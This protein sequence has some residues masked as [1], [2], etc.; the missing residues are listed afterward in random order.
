MKLQLFNLTQ[1]IDGLKELIAIN[2]RDE[3]MVLLEA[4]MLELQGEDEVI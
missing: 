4:R 1:E 2:P 3:Y